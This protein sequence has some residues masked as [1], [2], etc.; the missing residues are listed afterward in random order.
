[1]PSGP[2][3]K[4]SRPPAHVERLRVRYSDTDAQ[5]IAHHSNYFRW[6][7]E[8]RIGWL[9]AL[10]HDY[11]GL[12]RR[13]VFIPLTSCACE[14]AAPLAAGDT[15]DV[16]LWLDGATRVRANFVYEVARGDLVV[17]RGT[18]AHAIV[19][20]GGRPRRLARND[21]FWFSLRDLRAQP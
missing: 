7:E 14:F 8:A 9:A 3:R 15:V 11:A 12:N 20:A 6:L 21:P 13:G 19:D 4:M 1:M 2:P 18:S 17:A 10:G 5:G 16:R